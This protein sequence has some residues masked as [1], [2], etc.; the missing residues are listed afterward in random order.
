MLSVAMLIVVVL[1]AAPLGATSDADHLAQLREAI[2]GRED[3][4]AEKVFANVRVLPETVPGVTAAR[5]LQIMEL[6]YSRGLGV[7][8]SHCHTPG[9][10]A[11]DGKV[12]KR[13]ARRMS[14]MT[15]AI[16]SELLPQ[17]EELRDR[18]PV[19]SCATCHR[20]QLKPLVRM[21]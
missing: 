5:L 12:P 7:G 18:R 2:R 19:V 6:A 8:C 14:R 13:I 21:D 1:C 17:I 3:E 15:T 20:G 10:W 11:D 16:T 4:P 9:R